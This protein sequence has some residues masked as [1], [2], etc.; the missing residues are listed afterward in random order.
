[1]NGFDPEIHKGEVEGIVR[2]VLDRFSPAGKIVTVEDILPL[3][4][5]LDRA[6]RRIKRQARA[7]TLQQPMVFKALVGVSGELAKAAG[8]IG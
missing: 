5:D 4:E 6:A 1:M 7:K 8:L 2:C 3:C